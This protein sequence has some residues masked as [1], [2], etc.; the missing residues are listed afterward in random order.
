MRHKDNNYGFSP[1]D[2]SGDKYVRYNFSF[3]Y[4]K[5]VFFSGALLNSANFTMT[6]LSGADLSG[7]NLT[8]AKVLGID[9]SKVKSIKGAKFGRN[10]QE[11]LTIE[12]MT[13]GS[14][15]TSQQVVM[16]NSSYVELPN[17]IVDGILNLLTSNSLEKEQLEQILGIDGDIENAPV[18][19]YLNK[20]IRGINQLAVIGGINKLAVNIKKDDV[21]NVKDKINKILDCVD[22]LEKK[23]GQPK[24]EKVV[25]GVLE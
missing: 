19:T 17:S 23:L 24:L 25:D 4:L 9:F 1:N 5:G 18:K 16:G 10:I 21:T 12:E 13:D 15:M 20:V 14:R 22:S 2:L 7:A 8:G 11:L 3:K 6:N